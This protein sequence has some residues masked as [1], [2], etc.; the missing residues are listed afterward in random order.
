MTPAEFLAL[1]QP[2]PSGS[3]TAGQQKPPAP[4]PTKPNPRAYQAYGEGGNE[5]F[6]TMHKAADGLSLSLPYNQVHL[7]S[8]DERGGTFVKLHG[9]VMA[10]EFRGR[11]LWPLMSR[12]RVRGCAHVYEFN[13]GR[14][15]PPE[16]GEA[17]VM[18]I[19]AQTRP[20]P[21]PRAAAAQPSKPAPA[22]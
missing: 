1:Y 20:A 10:V 21:Q 16:P 3:G 19:V 22:A 11:N 15:D 2:A 13:G 9:P 5:T 6:V 12:L 4:P 8:C 17:V 7:V 14:H 18:Q